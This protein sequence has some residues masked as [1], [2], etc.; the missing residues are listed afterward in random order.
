MLFVDEIST[1]TKM[2]FAFGSV[3]KGPALVSAVLFVAGFSYEW[4]FYYNFGVEHLARQLPALS[5]AIAAFETIRNPWDAL[6]AILWVAGPQIALSALIRA[7]ASGLKS[8]IPVVRSIAQ[9]ITRSFDAGNGLVRD[10]A[11]AFLLVYGAAN[12]G[13]AAG[14][15][16]YYSLAIEGEQALPRVTLL[17]TD[18]EMPVVCQQ[19]DGLGMPSAGV[20]KL[21]TFIG[22]PD[23]LAD[24]RGGRACNLPGQWSWRLLYRD[25]KFVYLFQT[26]QSTEA[27]RPLTLVVPNS[28]KLTLILNAAEGN[29]Q[30]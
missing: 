12:A 9:V 5:T 30:H 2:D 17:F 26:V 8:P 22:N 4:S 25:D 16:A 1:A 19:H 11:A 7:A 20:G 28:D 15:N 3:L 10:A 23:A 18:G 24:L 29:G 6:Y 27:R 14:T 21:D 13:T